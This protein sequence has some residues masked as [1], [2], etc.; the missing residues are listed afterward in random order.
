MFLSPEKIVDYCDVHHGMKVADFGSSIG[1]FALLLA[2]RVGAHGTIYA[3]DIQKELLAKLHN[4]AKAQKLEN[5]EI[6]LGDFE[7][8]K[9]T[10]L[11]NESI[12]R[13]FVVNSFFQAEDKDA[14][15]NEIYRILKKGGKVIFIDWAESF[16]NLGPH[17]DSI[18]TEKQVTLMFEKHYFKKES[19]FPA[20]D[21]HYGIL[22]IK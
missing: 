19:D 14:C 17:K 1:T 20:G 2:K 3:I 9:G 7:K 13:V 12:D 15:I 8:E 11:H 21:H 4:E 10:M 5:V 22:F 18:V 6:I 16:E